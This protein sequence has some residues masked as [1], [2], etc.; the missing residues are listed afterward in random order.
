MRHLESREAGGRRPIDREQERESEREREWAREKE[1][2]KGGEAEEAAQ[3]EAEQE[4]RGARRTGKR[5]S[6]ATRR[7]TG[8][9]PSKPP[10]FEGGYVCKLWAWGGVCQQMAKYQ[11]PSIICIENK[12]KGECLQV[13]KATQYWQTY[14]FRKICLHTSFYMFLHML[15]ASPDLTTFWANKFQSLRQTISPMRLH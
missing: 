9:T 4:R 1:R 3:S 2:K 12:Y 11:F 14:L 8:N 6:I 7:N 10:R 5:K 13:L 15:L